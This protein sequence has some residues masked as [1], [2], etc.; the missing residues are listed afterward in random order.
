MSAALRRSPSSNLTL[1][2]FSI[3]FTPIPPAIHALTTTLF[4]CFLFSIIKAFFN[5]SQIPL[6]AFLDSFTSR[7][8]YLDRPLRANSG[9]HANDQATPKKKQGGSFGGSSDMLAIP[10]LQ[11][12]ASSLESLV[13]LVL[14]IG[15]DNA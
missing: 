10:H 1:I 9:K 14:N 5:A 4:D 3:K 6:S 8:E 12:I 11:R 15:V 2:D 13:E 7:V